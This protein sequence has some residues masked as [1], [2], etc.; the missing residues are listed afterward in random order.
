MK[1]R[2]L[3]L[4]IMIATLL[5]GTALCLT[6]CGEEDK[7]EYS[8]TV[9]SPEEEPLEGVTVSWL[10]GGKTAE[11][12]KTGADGKATAS[13]TPATYTIALADYYEGYS[14]TSASVSA[15]Q[16]NVNIELSAIMVRYSVA[17]TDKDGEPAEQVTATWTRKKDKVVAGSAETNGNGLATKELAYHEYIVTLSIPKPLSETN[18]YESPLTVNGNDPFVAFDL[19][20]GHNVDYTVTVKSEGELLF[21]NQAVQVLSGDLLMYSGNTDD[22]GQCTFSLMQG[23]YSVTASSLP[24][25]Y[26]AAEGTLTPAILKTDVVLHSEII[27]SAPAQ[28]K[29]YLMGDIFHDYT[30]T[31]SYEINGKIYSKSVSEILKD[32]QALIIN[33]WGTGCSNCMLE[34]PD[35][36]EVYEKYKDVIELVAVD[37]YPS[38][39]GIDTEETIASYIQSAGYT[40][41]AM[42]D[43]NGFTA[44]FGITGW[45]T[46]VIIDRYGA[47]ARI[48]VGAITSAEAW[49]RMIQKY[50]GDDYKQTFIPG[51]SESD[52]IIT[53]IAIPDIE[54]PENHYELLAAAMNDTN[55]FP[56]GAS[57]VWYGETEYKYAWPFIFGVD[58]DLTSDTVMYSSNT[59]K[60][61]SMSIL[62]ATVTVDAGKVLHFDYWAQTED[63]DVL[64]ILWDG[65][66]VFTAAGDSN[67]WQTCY[68]YTDLTG[69]SHTLSMA[70]IK[71]G[72]VSVGKDNVY[73]KRFGFADI[74]DIPQSTNMLRSAAYGVLEGGATQFPHYA[75][76]SLNDEDGYYYVDLSSLQNSQYAGN[77]PNPM[78]FANLMGVTGWDNEH[79]IAEW[80]TAQ[81]EYGEYVID[82]NFTIGGVKKDYRDTLM[83]YLKAAI[84]SYVDDCVPVNQELHDILVEFI[85]SVNNWFGGQTHDN[86]WLEICYF[87]SHYGEGEPIGNPILG[88]MTETAI[89]IGEGKTTADLTR[90]MPPFPTVI[91]TFTPTESAVYEIKSHIPA[92]LAD[93]KMSQIWLYDDNT[94]PDRALAYCGEG[95]VTRT[96]EDEQNAT[97][98]YYMTAGHKYYVEVAFLM[99]ET[100]SLDFTITNVGQSKTVLTPCSAD[101][102]NMVLDDKG[103]FTGE[104]YLADAIEYVKDQNG[105]YHAKNDDGSTGD[106]IYLDLKYATTSLLSNFPMERLV[107]KYWQDPAD[108]SNLDYKF[109]DFRYRVLFIRSGTEEN[110]IINYNAKVE[111]SQ[112]GSQYKDYT[113]TVKGWIESA[114]SNDGLL[115][116][117]Q[118][119]VDV[120]KLFIE[121]RIN[122]VY[123]NNSTQQFEIDPVLENEWL[124][125]CWYNKTYGSAE[126]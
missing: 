39:T 45:P 78:L 43:V 7:A 2:I 82:C 37:N 30:F 100:G 6:A 103:E 32:K 63:K 124:R 15:T 26:T 21:K 31:T 110:E 91:Y 50:I 121:M 54:I 1:K 12:V 69:G 62:Y 3:G 10:S 52:S 80:A 16:R 92:A 119:V 27:T 33:N 88:V 97:L 86:E 113:A 125:F 25:G 104:I 58:T 90:D 102:Y 28:N 23:H 98:Y 18:I 49:E 38:S 60:A 48:E 85:K 120:L 24:E 84:P 93:S 126:A 123:F 42:R 61:N 64:S 11:K 29:R 14:Y 40:F 17:V 74:E 72:T 118:E 8:V 41:P 34:M 47:V 75:S 53:E 46:T 73:F 56:N 96:G 101:T 114:K 107:D 9:Y 99:S 77:D 87:Y 117:N 122:A 5:F 44:K 81:D 67:G 112:Y 111:W 36:Q 109:F 20:E 71:N 76:V 105:Y 57:I 51:E 95:Y 83:K 19:V 22:N 4:L 59:G 89:E 106:F 94:D 79:S 35:M 115:K 116:V 55:L 70:Y 65:K 13:L 66:I 108:Y 68:L